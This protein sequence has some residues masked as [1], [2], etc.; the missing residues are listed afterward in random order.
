MSQS[1]AAKAQQ[2]SEQSGLPV[3]P[4]PSV[5]NDLEL[6]L[7][8]DH[9]ELYDCKLDTSV[10]IDFLHG[11]LAH[12]QQYGGGRGQAIAKAVGLKQGINPSVL[13]VT[14]GL[15]ADAFVLAT[16]G[17][18]ITMIERSPVVAALI[19]DAIERAILN[20]QFQT[21]TEQGFE[22][23]NADA[24]EYMQTSLAHGRQ[25]HDVV[26]IDPMYPH[27]KKSAL[28]KKNM[29][30]LQHLYSMDQD[31]E[32]NETRLLEN[33]LAYAQKR[34][35]VKRPSFAPP[36]AN[37]KPSTQVSSKKTRY[38]VYAIKKM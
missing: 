27:R 35:V 2:I 29:Q 22:L 33:A 37:R 34:V 32:C 14:A 5:E 11:T 8:A 6:R 16:L 3:L 4:R 31:H 36:L 28:V 12:R 23:I 1:K 21:I 25:T 15:A 7:F 24:N 18:C 20:E 17:C 13:D 19:E 10:V 26:Y 38:D 30:I 9:S